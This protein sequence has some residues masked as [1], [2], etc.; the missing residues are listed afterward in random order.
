MTCFG[1]AI[2]PIMRTAVMYEILRNLPGHARVLDL[3]CGRGSFVAESCPEAQV[4]RLDQSLPGEQGV[5]GFVR[6]DAARLPFSDASFDAVISNHSLEHVDDL[7]DVLDEIR[8]VVRP[9]GSLYVAVPDA[10]TF[11]DHLYRWIF[12]GGGHINAFRSAGD[13]RSEIARATGLQ[14]VA[15]R[16]LHTSLRFLLRQNF[17]PRPP[18]RLWIV[19][20]GN[21]TVTAVLTYILRGLDRAFGTRASVY[22]WAFYFGDVREVVETTPWTNVCV[23][24]GAGH[25]EASLTVNQRVRRQFG[26]LR[27]YDCPVCGAWNLFTTDPGEHGRQ[28][29]ERD[30][31][32]SG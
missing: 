7:A 15:T 25:S 19:G 11:S 2:P 23:N 9:N 21:P 14:P 24:C 16:V 20:N 29:V 6:A 17:K 12:H 10:S 26:W 8:R 4:V 30:K 28:T 18:R 13:L 1:P 32:G 5:D 31:L 22:G 27:S 3:G